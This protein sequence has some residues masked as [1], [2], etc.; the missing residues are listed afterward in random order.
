MLPCLLQAFWLFQ[1][2]SIIEILKQVPLDSSMPWN[3]SVHHSS[4]FNASFPSQNQY[5]MWNFCLKLWFFSNTDY[6]SWLETCNYCDLAC[7]R[8]SSK[9]TQFT[10]NS[11][12]Q[13]IFHSQNQQNVKVLTVCWHTPHGQKIKKHQFEQDKIVWKDLK[14]CT[15]IS[16]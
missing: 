7:L 8:N 2:P 12:F 10:G 5:K 1:E 6:H 4:H 9:L 15:Y 14:I 16:P 11:S 13:C 3:L